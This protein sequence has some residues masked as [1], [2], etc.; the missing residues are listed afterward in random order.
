MPDRLTCKTRE[1][2][3]MAQTLPLCELCMFLCVHF[4]EGGWLNLKHAH[5][6]STMPHTCKL[7]PVFAMTLY[8]HTTSTISLKPAIFKR[9]K[10]GNKGGWL[11][12]FPYLNYVCFTMCINWKAVG[13]VTSMHMFVDV[14]KH[15]HT[16]AIKYVQGMIGWCSFP[17][18]F[19]KTAFQ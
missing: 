1:Q 5:V 3:R 19:K 4:M 14:L 7:G 15:M 11:R 10:K 18:F 13:S 16:T 9:A 2:K 12:L 6:C 17:C 8:N